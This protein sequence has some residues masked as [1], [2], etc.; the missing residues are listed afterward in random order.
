M[1]FIS[2]YIQIRMM[3]AFRI[4]KNAFNLTSLIND[5]KF[6][7]EGN[8]SY[9]KF[10]QVIL[11]TVLLCLFGISVYC[12]SPQKEAIN[13]VRK[14][15]LVQYT[16]SIDKVQLAEQV[17]KW[18][19]NL[20]DDGSW[21][22]LNYESRLAGEGMHL[23][24]IRQMAT[25]YMLQGDKENTGLHQ[26]IEKG[27]MF[28][29][30]LLPEPKSD[31][32]WFGTISIPLDAGY[33]ILFMQEA[34]KQLSEES[35]NGLLRW[36]KKS[37]SIESQT[38]TELV[39]MLGIGMHYILRGCVTYDEMP[40]KQAVLYVNQMLEPDSGY[41]GIKADY[42][43]QAHG[44][45][46][47]SHGYGVPLLERF[48]R[49]G[50]QL[51]G[52][53][54]AF[55]GSNVQ[56][57]YKFSHKTLFKLARGQFLDYNVAGRGISRPRNIQARRLVSLLSTYRYLDSPDQLENYNAAIARFSG[58]EAANYKILPEHLQLW[59]SDYTA[60][61]RP[62]YFA[63]LRMISTRIVKPEK[64]NGESLLEHFRGNGAMSVMVRGNEYD[65]IFPVWK[66]NQIPG[67]TVPALKDVSGQADWFFNYGKTDFV[68]GVSDGEYGATAYVMDD[69]STRA[70][71]S[72]FFF[73]RQIVCLGAGITSSN[74]APLFTTINQSLTNGGVVIKNAEGVREYKNDSTWNNVKALAIMND[75]VGY[76]F[77][78]SEILQISNGIQT[79]SWSLISSDGL[80]DTVEKR[81]FKLH[82]DHG[83]GPKGSSYNYII[84]PG[85]NS[86]QEMGNDQV[87]ILCNTEKA[88]AVYNKNEDIC[89]V[90]FYEGTTLNFRKIKLTASEPCIIMIRNLNSKSPL[91][92][93]ADPTQ[94]LRNVKVNLNRGKKN[95]TKEWI[96]NLPQGV[97]AGSSVQVN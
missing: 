6:E 84:W 27:V 40:I 35:V 54:F 90:V 93:V 15:I 73:D 88:Q 1:E 10:F 94:K 75:E 55:S 96:C 32:W 13:H 8:R 66:W 57:L 50:E 83:I 23:V 18:T 85:I 67:T 92:I 3:N 58:N 81:V 19:V 86:M 69:Y 33:I 77:P 59:C 37:R 9:F 82:I 34:P 20:S 28:W 38:S 24:R 80:K 30:S 46:L 53:S 29:L 70:K 26:K 97:M 25:E 36:M 22:D 61:I 62:E 5:P 12:Q 41:T 63:S 91:I 49:M 31:N 16:E 39:R 43:Y 52:T 95:G 89:Q 2:N 65:D 11:L 64:G 78:G 21:P 17:Q 14:N 79:G 74:E 44:A 42:S 72:W 47:Y 4:F 51:A 48:A 56:E 71:K 68:G 7:S 60:H 76:S 45:Q 87:S